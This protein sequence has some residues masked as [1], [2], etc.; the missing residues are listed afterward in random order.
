[1]NLVIDESLKK[2]DQLVAD[3]FAQLDPFGARANTLKELARY[4]VE[5]KK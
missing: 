2:A 5:R 4:L 1:M 3:A